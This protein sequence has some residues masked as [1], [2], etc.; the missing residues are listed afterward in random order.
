MRF[1]GQVNG[2]LRPKKNLILAWRVLQ[3]KRYSTREVGFLIRR[4]HEQCLG[5]VAGDEDESQATRQP[6]VCFS[7]LV[8]VPQL[9]LQIVLAGRVRRIRSKKNTWFSNR[10]ECDPLGKWPMMIKGDSAD[11]MGSPR[12]SNGP[13]KAFSV[14]SLSSGCASC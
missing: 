13:R 7:A 1:S 4:L 6:P 2:A 5:Y 11:G 12:V 8:G 9:D 3:W 14:A 10:E